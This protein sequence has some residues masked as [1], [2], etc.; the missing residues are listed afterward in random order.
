MRTIAYLYDRPRSDASHMGVDLELIF[1]DAPGTHRD[2]LSALVDGAGIHPG[3]VVRVC[4]LSDLGH[5][6]ASKLMQDRIEALGATIEVMPPQKIEDGGRLSKKHPL[7]AD[8]CDIWWSA[9]DQ[10]DAL[11][12]MSKAAGQRVN[13][14]QANRLCKFT[15]NPT[16]RTL[17]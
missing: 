5:G 14:N 1:T 12:K 7:R 4:A 13:R 3:D 15:R 6:A 8:L 17:D 10:D 9:L 16:D 2:D 11:H